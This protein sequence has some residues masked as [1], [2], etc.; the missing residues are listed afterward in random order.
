MVFVFINFKVW[1][2]LWLCGLIGHCFFFSFVW[3]HWEEH[4]IRN[5]F[6]VNEKAMFGII[7]RR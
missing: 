7:V 5:I 6:V 2:M 1:F 3:Y 4:G